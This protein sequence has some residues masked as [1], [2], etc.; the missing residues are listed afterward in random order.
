MSVAARIN[1][2][3]GPIADPSDVDIIPGLSQSSDIPTLKTRVSS[4]SHPTSGQ[5]DAEECNVPVF[6]S[7]S[8]LF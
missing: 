6:Q 4:A 5:D 3:V 8:F 2:P 7:R 1:F